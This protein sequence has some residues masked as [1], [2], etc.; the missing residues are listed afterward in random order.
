MVK[1]ILIPSQCF[2]SLVHLV[3]YC[4]RTIYIQ[5]CTFQAFHILLSHPLHISTSQIPLH[6]QTSKKF[7][8]PGSNLCL[9]L[10]A[11]LRA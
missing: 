10:R 4:T 7:M 1:L 6:S 3:Y 8:I 5:N 2:S 11:E 9:E